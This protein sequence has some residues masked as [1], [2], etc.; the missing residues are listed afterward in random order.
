METKVCSKCDEEKELTEFSKCKNSKDGLNYKCKKCHND[1]MKTHYSLHKEE[2][3]EKHRLKYIRDKKKIRAKHKEWNDSN[4]DY[5]ISY[6]KKYEKLH[7][8]KRNAYKVNRRKNSIHVK[9]MTCLRTRVYTTLKAASTIKSEHLLFFIGCSIEELKLYLENQ[10][11]EGM[12]WNNYGMF[13]WHIDHKIPCA[14]FDLSIIEEQ[15]KCFHYTNLQ[16]L[17]ALDNWKK[18]DK[19]L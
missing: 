4:K 14:K 8:I 7:K 1:F 19:L 5:M 12:N 16:P 11:V 17:W 3:K 6:R 10:F 9:I 15:K 13:G 2:S 18:G